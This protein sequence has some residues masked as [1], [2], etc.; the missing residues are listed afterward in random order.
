MTCLFQ[1]LLALFLPSCVEV[2]AQSS[3]VGWP[4]QATLTCHGPL[5]LLMWRQQ[6]RVRYPGPR[7]GCCRCEL[8]EDMHR[9][10]SVCSTGSCRQI[11]R[12]PKP[13]GA[14]VLSFLV[15]CRMGFAR[16]DAAPLIAFIAAKETNY[17]N[18]TQGPV[19]CDAVFNALSYIFLS[20]RTNASVSF[21]V[22]KKSGAILFVHRS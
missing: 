16:F 14:T 19:S 20:F 12:N 3:E 15:I 10:A 18:E 9:A 7:S 21:Q 5:L 2:G 11:W 13:F 4:R 17:G 1:D 8:A 22:R 6:C